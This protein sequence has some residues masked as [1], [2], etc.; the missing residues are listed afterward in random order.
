MARGPKRA[1]GIVSQCIKGG[2]VACV[3]QKCGEFS[4]REDTRSLT[5]SV[6]DCSIKRDT[7]DRNIE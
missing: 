3:V 1:P 6:A 4:R 2:C 7:K 5:W